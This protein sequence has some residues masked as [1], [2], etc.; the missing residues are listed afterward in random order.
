MRNMSRCNN[1]ILQNIFEKTTK[2]LTCLVRNTRLLV[3]SKNY[4]EF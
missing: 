1:L 2:V 3:K 4:I